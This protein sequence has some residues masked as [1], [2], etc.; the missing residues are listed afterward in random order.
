MTIINI[1]QIIKKKFYKLS[2][3]SINFS[4]NDLYPQ[5][6]E[7]AQQ[8]MKECLEYL[9]HGKENFQVNATHTFQ[10][11]VQSLYRCSTHAKL[12]PYIADIDDFNSKI[13]K[14]QLHNNV[15]RSSNVYI[16]AYCIDIVRQLITNPKSLIKNH[17]LLLELSWFVDEHNYVFKH[18]DD[19]VLYKSV[20]YT[21]MRVI[22][23]AIFLFV[24]N[25]IIGAT[26]TI[27]L[28]IIY[29]YVNNLT[30]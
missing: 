8:M 30:H 23:S 7:D 26:L 2:R 28:T 1:C 19:L 13:K 22:L 27:I 21:K 15:I 12:I 4:H 18:T 20:R 10:D 6:N 9:E 3:A 11:K 24:K 29:L 25:M 5:S 16:A 14:L 17:K